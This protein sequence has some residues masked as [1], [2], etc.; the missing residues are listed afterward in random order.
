M[1][2]VQAKFAGDAFLYENVSQ[3]V[4]VEVVEPSIL[5]KYSLYIGGG[6][7][8][9]VIVGVVIYWKKSRE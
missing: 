5:V 2:R 4:L 7:G 1:W 8:A 6:I 3:S 9:A